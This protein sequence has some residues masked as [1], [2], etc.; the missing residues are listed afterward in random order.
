MVARLTFLGAARGV[1]GSCYHLEVDGEALLIDCGTF[2]GDREAEARNAAPL[3]VD[4]QALRALVFTHG[5]L[6]HVGRAPLLARAGFAGKV[7]GHGATLDIAKI[8]LEDSAAIMQ[9]QRHGAPPAY[10]PDDVARLCAGMSPIAGYGKPVALG[11]F[12][13]TFFDAGHIL[14]SASVRV[15]W[16]GGHEPRAILFSGDL[17]VAGA[18]LLRDPHTAWD[19]DR[20]AVEFVVT[21]STYG[22]RLHAPRG[23]VRAQL[24]QVIERSLR[25]GGKVLIPA[26]SIG[27]TQEVLYELNTMVEAGQLAGVPVVVDGPLGLSATRIYERYTECYDQQAM[28][29]LQ[30]GDRPLEFDSLHA[31]ADARASRAAVELDGP[32]V[33]IAGS[34]MCQGGR[35]R[36]HLR[37]HLPDPR[38]DVLLVGYQAGR[39]IGRDLQ[40]GRDTVFLDGESVPVRAKV[41]TIS[42]LSAHADRDGLTD[43]FAR[44]PRRR[45]GAVFVT[46]GEEEQSSKYAA[47]LADR[48]GVRAEVPALH[49]TVTLD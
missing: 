40:E 42:G 49:Q 3:A 17:G 30:R 15:E 22:D 10:R 5:H 11:P 14:G 27:R 32:A 36:H 24:Q 39:T 23:E 29:L 31:A 48:F 46:H 9:H 35:I 18:P 38:T 19:P 28:Q 41:T 4:A 47:R 25:D 21:E 13:L 44:V 7:L 1:T 12:T 6:D 2:Q 45:G 33:I 8:I 34:G 26:F 43:W 16:K 37:R 20:D